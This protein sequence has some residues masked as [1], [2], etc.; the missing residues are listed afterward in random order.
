MRLLYPHTLPTV[1]LPPAQPAVAASTDQHLPTR[2]PGYSRNYPWMPHKSAIPCLPGRVAPPLYLPDEEFSAF[3]AAAPRGQPRP[4]GTPGHA[5]NDSMMPRQPQQLRPIRC[6]PHIHVA[7]ITPADQARPVRT[8][9]HATDP[10]R[11]LTA[12][13][14]WGACRSVPY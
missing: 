10:G 6:V 8:P 4:I 1:D 13:P 5:R 3:S 2:N 12:H 7:I 11:G 14:A 9:S